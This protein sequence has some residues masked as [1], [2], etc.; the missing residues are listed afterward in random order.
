MY[1]ER[2]ENSF[3]PFTSLGTS[4][5]SFSNEDGNCNENVVITYEFVLLKSLCDYS[6]HFNVTKV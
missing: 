2:I 4:I 5:G 1:V 6:K 3:G